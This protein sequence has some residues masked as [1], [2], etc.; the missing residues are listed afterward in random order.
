MDINQILK[1]CPVADEVEVT[2]CFLS[3][4]KAA[5]FTLVLKFSLK[6]SSE[7]VHAVSAAVWSFPVLYREF[8]STPW[9][10]GC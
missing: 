1:C 8:E 4:N 9:R 7:T 2:V 3:S 10:V 5:A 6:V